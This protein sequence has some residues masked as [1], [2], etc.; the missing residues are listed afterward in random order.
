[1]GTSMT[2]DGVQQFREAIRSAGLIPPDAIEPGKFHKFPG[3]GKRNG[4][5]AAWC[6]LFPDGL[7]GIYGDYSTGRSTDWQAKRESR[8]TPAER[9][10][11]RRHIAEARAQAE[12]ERKAKQAEAASKAAAIWQAAQPAPDNHPYLVRK[13]IKVHGLRE[14][15]GGLVVP[16]RDDGEL[17][18]LQFIGTDG[19]KRF[20]SGGRVTGCYYSIGTTK[21]AAALCIAQGYATAATIHEATGYPVAV[22]FNAGNLESV[23]RALRA[24]FPDLVLI[25]CADDDAAT[26]GNPGLT[27]AT[28]AARAV[29]SL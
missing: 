14:H 4:N 18:S 2:A 17:H 12:A 10:A 27:K 11:F 16:M 28:A 6:K 13:G 5:T 20:L 8:Y 1:M 19:N 26:E 24:N 29:G 25:L 23:A 7:G 22:A 15:N 9:E 21:G 3:E